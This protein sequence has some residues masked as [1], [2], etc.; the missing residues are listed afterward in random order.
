MTGTTQKTVP[1]V[2]FVSLGCPKAL[3]DTERI[4]TELRAEG[5][6]IARDYRH[7]DIVI[8]NTCAFID[9][10]VAESIEAITEAMRENGRV[11]VTGCLG[12]KKTPEGDNWVMQRIPKL[13][14]VTGPDSTAETRA[15][16]SAAA[17]RTVFGLSP[18]RGPQTH[19]LALR[20][21]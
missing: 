8:V 12:G 2:G 7:S 3:V 13:L 5:Y 10:A 6:L 11:I 19:A 21:P 9:A 20:L 16:A 1:S 4:V 14:G 17:A 18:Q 15:S